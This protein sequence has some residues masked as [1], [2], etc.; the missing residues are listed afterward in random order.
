MDEA[1]LLLI[2]ENYLR[3]REDVADATIRSGRVSGAVR[4]VTVTKSQ[5][6]EVVRAVI[7][8]GATYLGENYTDE[9]LAKMKVIKEK[10]V[11]W[12]MIGHV[13][14]R[15][16]GQIV[17][18]FDMIHSVDSEKLA[19]RLDRFTTVSNRTL[20]ALLEINVSGETSKY[21]LQAWDE[22]RWPG[23]EPLISRITAFPHINIVGLMT[24][25]PLMND[26]EQTRPFFQRLRR[27]LEYLKKHI[28]QVKWAELSMGTSS[29]YKV[30]IEEGATLVRVGRSI[31]GPRPVE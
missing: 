5:P 6:V 26:P 14:S 20:Q 22:K 29:D 10:G 19:G 31:L 15:K 8:A 4:L 16:A 27:L 2:R 21:G 17:G 18:N 9:A 12:H 30:A 24:M 28:P 11:E 25:P 23:L 1:R 7:A 3:V 13:Q